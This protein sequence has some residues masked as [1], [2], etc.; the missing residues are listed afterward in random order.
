MEPK[1]ISRALRLLACL[2]ALTLGLAAQ[3]GDLTVSAAASLSNA[4]KELA[5]GFEAQHPG[6]RV[7]LNFGA[8]D[9]LLA[10]IS[11]GAPV[12]V[13]LSLIHI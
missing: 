13:F 8:S 10:Q 12:D 9:A 4:F 7:L 1:P 11:K 6:T 3:A 2:A 5:P